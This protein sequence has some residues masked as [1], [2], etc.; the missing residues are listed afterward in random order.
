MNVGGGLLFAR[1]CAGMLNRSMGTV[2]ALP[3]SRSQPFWEDMGASE[4]MVQIY[5]G[6]AAFLAALEGFVASALQ[7]GESAIVIATAAHLHA[8]EKR[9][10]DAGVDVEASRG[11]DRYQGLLAEEVLARILE[12]R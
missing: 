11:E 6:D 5:G 4:H 3:N 2:T 7:A 10:R 9:L 8:I 12:D 1:D